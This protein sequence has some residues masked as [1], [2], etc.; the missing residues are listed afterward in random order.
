MSKTPLI[1]LNDG[2]SWADSVP[3][4]RTDELGA[5]TTD[6]VQEDDV[7]AESLNVTENGTFTAASAG[8]YGYDTVTVSVGGTGC[9]GTKDGKTYEV[10]VDPNTGKLVYTEVEV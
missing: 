10:T 5:S 3:K 7:T 1:S 4:L 2:T 9:I 8:K 6:W